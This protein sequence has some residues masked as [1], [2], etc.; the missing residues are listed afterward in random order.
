MSN[1]TLFIFEHLKV[2]AA[3]AVQCSYHMKTH[4]CT[5]LTGLKGP[6]RSEREQLHKF[7]LLKIIN[8]LKILTSFVP[9]IILLFQIHT[10]VPPKVALQT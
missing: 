10:C 8:I 6:D 9:N 4:V 5:T 1:F 3:E 7:F 2:S